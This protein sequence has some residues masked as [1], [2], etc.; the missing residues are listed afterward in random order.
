LK[1][2][3]TV[4]SVAIGSFDG[5]HIAHQALL[6]KAE[7]VVIIERNGG[8][9][10]PGYKRSLYTEKPCY[11][12]HFDKIRYLSPKAF[13]ERL[14]H[15]FPLL[16]K[17]VVGYD[18]VFG[19]G[20]SGDAGHLREYFQ[21]DVEVVGEITLDGISV[22]SRTIRQYLKEGDVGMAKRLLG[23]SYQIDGSVIRGQGLGSEKLVSTINLRVAHYQLPKEGVY[24]TR[25]YVEDEW[26][27]SVSFLGHRVTTD[28]SFAVET[29]VIDEEVFVKIY[30]PVWIMFESWIRPNRKFDSLQSLKKQIEDDIQQCRKFWNE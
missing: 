25:T 27:K 1:Y 16:E 4:K 20:K 21:G 12:Y 5:I 14:Q 9:L 30:E 13:V 29:H 24:V 28:G 17:I 22:H 7:A 18:F 2:N 19:K 8:Y 26:R 11:F 3:N 15:D 6:K 23:R 10:T